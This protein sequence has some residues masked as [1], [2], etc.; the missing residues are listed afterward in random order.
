MKKDEAVREA[1]ERNNRRK[2][3]DPFARVM[4]TYPEGKEFM[5]TPLGY[6][7]NMIPAIKESK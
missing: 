2:P 7:I 1:R 4:P 5:V 6:V 3:G